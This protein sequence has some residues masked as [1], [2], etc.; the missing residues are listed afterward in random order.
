M[1]AAPS[2]NAICFGPFKLDLKA[3]EVRQAAARPI[4]LPEQPF[5]IPIVSALRAEG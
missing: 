2:E 1:E 5:R 3:G 4:H